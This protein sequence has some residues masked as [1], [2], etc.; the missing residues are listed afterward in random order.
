VT[1]TLEQPA[2]DLEPGQARHLDVEEDEVQLVLVERGH[3]LE[4]VAGLEHNVD[5]AELPELVTQLVSSELLVIHDHHA[6]CAH[7]VICSTAI[8]SGTSIR[9]RNPLP[10][11]LFN[12]S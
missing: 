4:P 8:S 12:F 3:G 6:K 2:S 7:A 5:V 1:N 11:S 10:G 9:A